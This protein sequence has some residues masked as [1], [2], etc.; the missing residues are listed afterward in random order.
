VTDPKALILPLIA[1]AGLVG[2]WWFSMQE[3]SPTET[4]IAL[5]EQRLINGNPTATRSEKC[6]ATQDVRDAYLADGDQQM[7]E[8]WSNI[9]IG[10]CVRLIGDN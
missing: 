6:R 1:F 9:A 5:N 7:Y 10:S 4:E 3:Q 8:I 2:V